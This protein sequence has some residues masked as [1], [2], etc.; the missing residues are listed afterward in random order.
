MYSFL[1]RQRIDAWIQDPSKTDDK[2]GVNIET[3]NAYQRRLIYQEVRK[4]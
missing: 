2:D 3:R 4:Q 1:D